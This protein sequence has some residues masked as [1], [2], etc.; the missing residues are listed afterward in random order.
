[1]LNKITAKQIFFSILSSTGAGFG[2]VYILGPIFGGHGGS[3]L[4]A[5]IAIPLGTPLYLYFSE[6]AICNN[7]EKMV[8]N[9]SIGFMMGIISFVLLMILVIVLEH[10][11]ASSLEHNQ[12]ISVYNTSTH[13]MWTAALIIVPIV[14]LLGYKLNFCKQ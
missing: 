11:I 14:T 5:I 7:K 4:V 13:I 9:L 3:I 6:S 12:A 1:M 10:S 2:A 8:G